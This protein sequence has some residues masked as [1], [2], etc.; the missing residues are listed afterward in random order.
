MTGHG[1][2]QL[3]ALAEVRRAVDE[4]ELKCPV[5]AD[6]GIRSA[7]DIVKCMAFGASCVMLGSMLAATD[8]SCAE[9][10]GDCKRVRGMASAAALAAHSG[11]RQ[12][13]SQLPGQG[14]QLSLQQ[15]SKVTPEGVEGL[16]KAVGPCASLLQQ[17]RGGMRSGLAH[18]GSKSWARF[19]PLVW[20]QT[21]AGLVEGK[22][23]S[24]K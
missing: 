21:P 6:G 13:Y 2:P 19:N 12:R 15:Q 16:V 18:S 23:H 10:V 7:G 4:S 17:L 1:V 5:I 8:E 3:T 11:S 20:R 24:I 9:R 14:E 22:P